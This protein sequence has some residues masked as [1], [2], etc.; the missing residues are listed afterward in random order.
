MGLREPAFSDHGELV[1]D[2]VELGLTRNEARLYLAAS[3]REALRA[4]EL[5]ELAGV[6]RSKAYD[7]LR[8]LVDKGLLRQQ[9][10]RVARFQAA[11]PD[12]LAQR[13]RQRSVEDQAMLVRDTGALVA[14]LFARYYA[15]PASGDPFDFVE[16]IRNREAAWA[17]RDAIAAGARTEV[18]DARRLAP[19]G[20]RPPRADPTGP[21]AGV[22]HR[23]LYETGFLDD[24]DFRAEVAERE[25]HGEQV[26]FVEHVPVGLC[27]V[28]RRTSV[29]SLEQAA[30]AGGP[31]TWVVL[32]HD[33]LAA[34]F[35]DAF[36]L[37][38]A[39]GRPL[40]G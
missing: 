33:G 16:L 4:A 15:A 40:P 21:R 28:D 31:G 3:G 13:L 20:P 27:V 34:T 32:A 25:R 26:R 30:E 12:Q 18:V 2:L 7:A 10:G 35:A 9:P 37:A 38:W 8:Q 14:D 22:R 19:D 6:T 29:L 24:H 11:D 23:S 1:A 36:D 5:A 17:R 39:R